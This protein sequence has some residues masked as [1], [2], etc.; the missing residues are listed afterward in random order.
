[1]SDLFSLA[2]RTAL[3]TGGSSGIGTAVTSELLAAGARVLICGRD[4]Q[5]LTR[6][7][8]E[9]SPL[10]EVDGIPADLAT[11]PGIDALVE[12]VTN[13][14]GALHLLVNNAGTTRDGDWQGYPEAEW[15]ATFDL[16]VKAVHYL[17]TALVP[18]LRAAA[19]PGDPARVV[20]V[21]SMDGV[22]PMTGNPA[23]GASKA[24]VHHL[25]RI[26]ARALAGDEITVNAVAPGV[27][28]SRLTADALDDPSERRQLEHVIPLGRIGR[29]AE[30]G[31]TVVYLASRAGAFTTGAVL[32][33]DGGLTSCGPN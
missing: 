33:V 10:G 19:R 6:S 15:D 5:A 30:I 23:Y 32:A 21:G 2:G 11:R 12:Q 8:G 7:V 27:F 18:L 29:P 24:A 4:A 20:H 17:T 25:A 28:P 16:N 13:R 14:T 3:V 9:L 31:G 22:A 1:M 26:H